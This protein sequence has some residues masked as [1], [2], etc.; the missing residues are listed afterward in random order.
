MFG[1]IWACMAVG[2]YIAMCRSCNNKKH[3]KEKNGNNK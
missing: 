2:M 3:I 1:L